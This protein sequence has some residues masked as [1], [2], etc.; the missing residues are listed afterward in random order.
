MCCEYENVLGIIGFWN[1]EML[2]CTDEAT[3]NEGG[4]VVPV[5]NSRIS[6]HLKTGDMSVPYHKV[7]EPSKCLRYV[8]RTRTDPRS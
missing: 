8:Y 1:S 3:T 5:S 7:L 4:T 6:S 2:W